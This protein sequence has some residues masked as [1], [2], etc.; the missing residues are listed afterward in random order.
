MRE[1]AALACALGLGLAAAGL[2]G[3]TLARLG[4]RAGRRLARLV[5]RARPR[6]PARAADRGELA[7]L[8]AGAVLLL[9]V[10]RT[11]SQAAALGF[12]GAVLGLAVAR[13]VRRA[14]KEVVRQKKLREIAVFFEA[15]ELYLRAGYSLPQAMWA[16]SL[17]APGLK[18]A[19]D[20]CLERWPQGAR[21]A[22]ERFE[23]D[24]GVS[25]AQILV[26]LLLQIEA[27][28]IKNLEG[29][30]RREA[31]NLDRLRRLRA[32]ARIAS[33]PVYYMVYRF[34]PLA[35]TLVILVGPLLYRT[36]TVMR[37]AG[38]SPF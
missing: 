37:E 30:V 25:E 26:S 12:S 3:E 11:A 33:R 1:V 28:G 14:R 22:L 13:F 4:D 9:L 27:V 31:H 32:E 23:R 2:A 20:R 38:I 7:A 8:A 29:V 5:R 19:V 35:A 34:L 10:A 6:G 17:L 18:D 36:L 21:R 24:L 16:A 15:V